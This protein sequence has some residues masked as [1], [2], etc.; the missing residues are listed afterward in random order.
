VLGAQ[1]G[2][3]EGKAG[4]D[5]EAG[6]KMRGVIET[7]RRAIP[8]R[9]MQGAISATHAQVAAFRMARHDLVDADG[10]SLPRI[11]SQI[12]GVQA[13]VM[14][15][16]EI[17]LWA[18]N[19][20][21]NRA[22][23]GAAI[24]RDRTLVRTSCMRQTLHL[25]PAAEFWIYI[26]ALKSSRRAAIRR[27]M[28]RFGIREK[29]AE[30]FVERV[31]DTLS[32]G[33]LSQIEIRRRIEPQV[34]KRVRAWMSRFWSVCRPAL[35]EGLI[36]YGES[37]G[38]GNLYVRTDRW[39]TK[40][41]RVD[42]HE[43]QEFLLRNYLRAYGPARPQDYARWSGCTM[44]EV[45][46][47]WDALASD[48]AEVSLEGERNWILRK[49]AGELAAARFRAPVVRL[50][51]G[52]DP[53]LL[54]HA[55]KA[56]LVADKHYKKIYRDQWWITP[57]VLLDGRAAGIWELT[58]LKDRVLVNVEMFERFG[59]P[60]LTRLAEEA[61]SLGCFLDARPESKVELKIAGG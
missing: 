53:Y 60:L 47:V 23:I 55:T 16:A 46:P 12:C 26:E 9:K 8:S 61:E 37:R 35:V 48:M 20:R 21:L 22:A 49:N 24:S 27:G 34:G 54:A 41:R 1:N 2:Y 38:A 45:Q 58:R 39:L 5:V 51:P 42:A 52:F 43:A 6:E 40:Q 18:R 57:V 19:H 13:Q 36:C 44:K 10:G 32:G 17:A 14:S 29:E 31:V 7:S 56:H 11:C 25:I 15:A 33:P 30:E 4:A 59:K 3:G 50:L 28:S